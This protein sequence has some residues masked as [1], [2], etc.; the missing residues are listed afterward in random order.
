MKGDRMLTLRRPFNRI[1]HRPVALTRFYSCALLISASVLPAPAQAGTNTVSILTTT[2]QGFPS[3]VNYE[4]MGACFFLKCS[5]WCKIQTS[6]RIRHF[7]PDVVISTYNDHTLH[8]W[9]EIGKPLSQALSSVGTSLIGAPTDSSA[10]NQ[11]EGT[12]MAT[13]KSADAIGNPA[14]MITQMLSGGM[15]SFGGSFAFPSFEELMKFPSSL[16]SIASQW[17]QVP[18]QAGNELLESARSLAQA[19]SA[20]MS[21]ATSALGSAGN[22]LGGSMDMS[23]LGIEAPDL[24]SIDLGPVQ[25]LAELASSVA[26]GSGSDYFC[27]GAASPFT[28]HFQSDLDILFWRNI[29]PLEMLYPQSWVPGLGEVSTSGFSH[30]WGPTYPRTGEVVQSHPVKASA[31]FAARIGSIITQQAQ[32]HIYKYL[33]PGGGYKYFAKADKQ[34]WQMLYPQPQTSCVTFGSDDSL[35]LS[36]FGDY[37]TDENDGYMWSMWNRYDCCRSKG[38]FLFS[39]P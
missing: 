34:R 16:P 26:G 17:A 27:P 37:Q 39:V 24:T 21:S 19:P 9:V 38:A 7:V 4:L 6:V 2:L 31:V 33:Q 13:F 18:Q 20:L 29:I 1:F 3:C 12:E 22:M 36:S 15:S 14:G 28:L 25:D 8:P 10:N 30:T 35:T 5:P 23:Q 11:R 32:P